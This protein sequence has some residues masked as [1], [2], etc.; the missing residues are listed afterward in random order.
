MTLLCI[1]QAQ[2]WCQ[3]S[4]HFES[5]NCLNH[6]LAMMKLFHTKVS[7]PLVDISDLPL[8]PYPLIVQDGPL[9]QGL[10]FQ[11]PDGFHGIKQCFCHVV[12]QAIELC[13]QPLDHLHN[14]Q[15]PGE[16]YLVSYAHE[17]F[18]LHTSCR[19]LL[20]CNEK[21]ADSAWAALAEAGSLRLTGVPFRKL[22]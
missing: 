6:L 10:A 11:R 16:A 5:T 2:A 4:L 3:S 17:T 15:V 12:V 14:E 21:A 19:T 8:N 22:P 20:G 18:D 13:F 9:S 1:W 7:Q